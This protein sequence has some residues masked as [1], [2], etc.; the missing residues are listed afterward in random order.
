V[1]KPQLPVKGILLDL[2]EALSATLEIQAADAQTHSGYWVYPVAE[3]AV[4]GEGG[5]V[6]VGELFALDETAYSTAGLFPGVVAQLG[7]TYMFRGQQK[8]Q[9]I[10]YPL[11]FNPA[12]RELVHYKRIRVRVNYEAASEEVF[13]VKSLVGQSATA[14]TAE[15]PAMSLSTWTVP[16][17]GTAYKIFTADEGIYRLTRSFLANN[18]ID[19]NQIDLSQVRLYNLGQ[20]LPVSIYDQDGDYLLDSGDYIDFYATPVESQYAKYSKYNLYWLVTTSGGS[21]SPLRMAAIDGT[22]GSGAVAATHI[23]TVHHEQDDD[24]L[25]L[26][27]GDD[28]LDR[29]FILPFVYGAG[30]QTGGNPVEYAVSLPGVSNLGSLKIRMYGFY[31]TD[32][33][34][35]IWVNGTLV[36]T[37]TW[38]GDAFYQVTVDPVDLVAGINTITF[39]C[40]SG[41]DPLDPDGIALDWLE[42]VYPRDFAA[43][44]NMLKFSHEPGYRFQIQGF[45]ASDLSVFD[46]TSPGEVARVINFQT[47]GT[48]P[49]SVD[50]EPPV[51]VGERTYLVLS[52]AAVKTPVQIIE[53]VTAN[54]A[55]PANGADYIL[56]THRDLGWDGAGDPYPWLADLVTHRESQGLRVKVVDVEDIYDEFSYGIV[57]PVAVKDFLTFAYDNWT[58]PAPQYVLLGGDGTHDYKDN[59]N[60]GSI[61]FLPPYLTFTEYMGETL[62]DEWFAAVSGDDGISDLYIGRLPAATAAQA[63]VMVNKIIAYESA[64]NSKTWEKNVLLVADN[65]IESYEVAFETMND[66]AAQLIPPGLNAPFKGY[67]NNYLAAV[68]L[69][70]DLKDKINGGALL[71][72]YSGHGSIQLWADEVIFETAD[73]AD[74]TNDGKFPLFVSMSCL[75]GFFGYPE[76]WDFPSLAE[77]LMRSDGKGAAAALMPTGMTTPDGQHV[78]DVALFN[79]IFTEDTRTLGP[80]VALAKQTLL[81][82]GDRYQDISKTFLLFGDPAMRLKI[83]LPR[84][85]SQL[86]AQAHTWGVSLN[87]QEAT[88]CDGGPVVGYNLYRSTTPGGPYTRVNSSLI[89][90]TTYEDTLD[91]ASPR[92]FATIAADSGSTHYYVVTAVDSDGDESVHSSEAGVTQGGGTQ[93]ASSS[94]GGGGGSCFI[95]SAT[96]F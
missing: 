94:G 23:T 19:V 26:A 3:K 44:N 24:Y 21:G 10:F 22:P 67:L 1:G 65:Q 85:P 27:P 42:V 81:A 9:V 77:T 28:S 63:G 33:E 87:W 91:F 13:M 76:A 68:D 46:I 41:A 59:W 80:A 2:P 14:A 11:A 69:T 16:S 75:T 78:L 43:S 86:V 8:L 25:P 51:E 64:P 48:G 90:A 34:V 70:A 7:E 62:T 5:T 15:N 57:T 92:A 38:S 20:E 79:A 18:G 88:D 45:T 40:I 89:T 66:E 72:N 95:T 29:W 4:Q 58:Q 32:H 71:V 31:D 37:A 83:I 50:V 82:N 96:G 93:N 84:R 60:Q 52:S 73:V 53:D 61:N 54:L 35:D 56:I 30:I 17:S 74:L 55:D 6:H 36:Q 49:Y 12:T 47:T 39:Q